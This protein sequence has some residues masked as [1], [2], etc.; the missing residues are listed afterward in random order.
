[1]PHL[2]QDVYERIKRMCTVC[3]V[4]TLFC[5]SKIQNSATILITM[6]FVYSRLVKATI[7]LCSVLIANHIF[8]IIIMLGIPTL[9]VTCLLET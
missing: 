8:V 2:Q 7:L 9:C 5:P 1:M 4:T 6:V 3:R